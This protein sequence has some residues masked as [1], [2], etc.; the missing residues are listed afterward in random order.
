MDASRHALGTSL[1]RARLGRGATTPP[2]EL[3]LLQ[4][5]QAAASDAGCRTPE[6]VTAVY[7]GLKL[8]L[9]ICMYGASRDRTVALFDALTTTFVGT[10]SA[11][12]LHLHGPIRDDAMAQR[13]AALRLGEFVTS[14]IDPLEQDKAWFVVVDTPGD[15]AATLRWV[16]QEFAATL[17]AAGRPRRVLPPNIFVLIAAGEPP[18]QADHCWLML[19]APEWSDG[20]SVAT[21][22]PPVGY[23][24]HL[25]HSQLTRVAY[26]QRIPTASLQASL[27][28][29]SETQRTKR[30]LRWLA[31]SVDEHGQGLWDATDLN[32]NA[33]KALAA[34][35][36]LA[37][38]RL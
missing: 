37:E 17:R 14:A 9:R 38:R 29:A 3:L 28:A 24:R 12:T 35:D 20:R 7:V 33:R 25:L 36:E 31:A 32:M 11:Q 10:G 21:A 2:S 30:L 23:Q 6:I 26:R 13:F 34:L 18:T 16:E 4:R 15:P 19:R 8:H 1:L 22:L 27:L 5:L